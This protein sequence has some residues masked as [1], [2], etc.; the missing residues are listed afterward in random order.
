MNHF[1]QHIE[2]VELFDFYVNDSFYVICNLY[3]VLCTVYCVLCVWCMKVAFC[4]KVGLWSY[5]QLR[6]DKDAPN[7]I[8][9]V[10]S[11]LME[12]AEDISIE[13]LVERLLPGSDGGGGGGG[14]GVA[15]TKL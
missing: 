12:Q 15:D 13:E 10:M 6:K 8:N 2:F 9:T 1:W 4:P 14:V 3:S 5:F 11:I 7:F